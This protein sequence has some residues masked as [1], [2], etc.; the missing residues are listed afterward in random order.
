MDPDGLLPLVLP[1]V[2]ALAA[3]PL[4][5][6]LPPRTATWLLTATAVVLALASTA[7]LA[8]LALGGTLRLPMIAALGHLS[9][10]VLHRAPETSPVVAT[11]AGPALAASLAAASWA[12]ARRVRGLLAGAR[13]ARALPGQ[14]IVA[15]IDDDA[16]DAFALPGRVVVSTGMLSIL[17]EAE[18]RALLAHERAHLS[19]RHHVFRA[20]VHVA[21]A[22]NPLLL[23]LRGAVTFTTERWADERAA[24]GADRERVARAIGKAALAHNRRP[25]LG[26]QVAA[27][28][29][30]PG[31]AFGRRR[32]GPLPRRVAALLAP[33]PP[34]RRWLVIATVALA[35]LSVWAADDGALF[36][37]QLI[38]HA[39][40]R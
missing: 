33:P 37:H 12:A 18:R 14:G 40:T 17:D 13:A 24:A 1:A 7:S 11:V 3:R 31:R 35:L 16:A 23:P 36:L 26:P 25:G 4:S 27:L 2:M 15:V 34:L 10:H 8:E 19:G 6:R 28:G 30:G 5:G 22:A 20:L 38:E 29:I 32:P 9:E 39:Q 21:A